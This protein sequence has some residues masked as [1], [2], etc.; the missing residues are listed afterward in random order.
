MQLKILGNQNY[1]GKVVNS[2]TMGRPL[3][4]VGA[5][6]LHYWSINASSQT[7]SVNSKK[8]RG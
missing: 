4:I 5:G 8:T 3:H 7:N 2:A 1:R 6:A